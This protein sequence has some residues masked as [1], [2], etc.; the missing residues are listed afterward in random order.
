MKRP[1]D[2]GMMV[3]ALGHVE[4]PAKIAMTVLR[5][6]RQAM[7]LLL[8]SKCRQ[9]ILLDACAVQASLIMK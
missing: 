3:R 4:G 2:Q 9:F 7:D 6:I 5:S 8:Q 1:S